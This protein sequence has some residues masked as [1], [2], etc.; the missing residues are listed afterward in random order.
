MKYMML[1]CRDPSIELS[2]Q[3][4]ASMPGWVSAWVEEMVGRGIRLQ[5][6]LF[7]PASDARTVRIRDGEV[8]LAN[9]P[10]ADTRELISGYNIIDCTDLNEAIEVA[11]KHPIARFGAVEVRPFSQD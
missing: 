7:Q 4:R 11:T 10:F 8:Q 3:D 5:G 2:P 1:I 6:D 9:G